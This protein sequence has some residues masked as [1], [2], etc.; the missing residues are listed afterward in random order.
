MAGILVY[1]GVHR[2]PVSLGGWL[3]SFQSR[4]VLA[5]LWSLEESGAWL[6][7]PADTTRSQ[8]LK[9]YTW[10]SSIY[11]T[12]HGEDSIGSLT[13]NLCY[14][15]ELFHFVDPT[16][17]IVMYKF[18]HKRSHPQSHSQDLCT[19]H[20]DLDL[21]MMKTL[22]GCLN[23]VWLDHYPS[24]AGVQSIAKLWTQRLQ[25]IPLSSQWG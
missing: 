16:G 13:T 3:V 1:I 14:A 11:W 24:F 23:I 12:G 8:Y 6:H 5:S 18:L 25:S 9:W 17:H 22:F 10:E 15:R 19:L 4:S 2:H 7:P 21:C 20:G